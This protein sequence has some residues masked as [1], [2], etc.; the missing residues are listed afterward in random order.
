M[1]KYVLVPVSEESTSHHGGGP[2]I[3]PTWL[4]TLITMI[5]LSFGIVSTWIPWLHGW[6]KWVIFALIFMVIHIIIRTPIISLLFEV[7]NGLIWCIG[8]WKVIGII[9]FEWLKWGLR[10]VIIGGFIVFFEYRALYMFFDDAVCAIKDIACLIKG[11]KTDKRLRKAEKKRRKEDEK[12]QKDFWSKVRVEN[13]DNEE[14]DTE[15][16]FKK[17][18]FIERLKFDRKIKKAQRQAK[19]EQRKRDKELNNLMEMMEKYKK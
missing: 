11:N 16:Y 10:I 1:S 3:S 15:Q 4:T 17:A 14:D 13:T 2:D 19:R 9:P 5:V 8:L 12:L 7:I 18:S 6:I